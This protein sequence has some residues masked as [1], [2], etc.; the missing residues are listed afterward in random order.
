MPTFELQIDASPFDSIAEQYD[1]VFTESR[2][3][4]AQRSAVWA[5]FKSAFRQGDHV[6]EIG[7]GTGVDACFLAQQGV[8]VLACDRSREMIR[9]TQER[10]RNLSARFQRASVQPRVWPAEEIAQ[11]EHDRLFDGA[12]SNFGVLNCVSDLRQFARGLATLL[13]PSAQVLLCVMG[14][15]C[16][17]E[18]TWFLVRGQPRRA[19]R[20]F[21]VEGT[22]ATVGENG[23]VWVHYPSVRALK[24]MFAPEFRMRRV[25]GI[26]LSVPPTYVAAWVDRF[27]GLLW[28]ACHAD[29]ILARWPGVRI[30]ADHV[31]VTFERTEI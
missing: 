21:R 6:L 8:S 9:I 26:G 25:K 24:R 27:P 23:R 17:W 28:L 2:I 10:V 19:L 7:C 31:L 22:E 20:R 5:E 30:L 29:R 3:G 1:A 15:C 18:V 14:P 13:K 12:F 16:L 4:R 11:L